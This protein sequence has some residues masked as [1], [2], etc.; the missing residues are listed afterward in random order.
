MKSKRMSEGFR[1]ECEQARAD[2][3]IIAPS[4]RGPF[5]IVR[6]VRSCRNW[7][8]RGPDGLEEA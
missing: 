3:G 8:C 7:F 5:C 1:D 6:L 4:L 2:A